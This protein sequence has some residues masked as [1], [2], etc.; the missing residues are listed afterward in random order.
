MCV[1]KEEGSCDESLTLT[2]ERGAKV[3]WTWSRPPCSLR[4]LLRVLEPKVANKAIHISPGSNVPEAPHCLQSQEG[5]AHGKGQN[6][7]AEAL[8]QL[9]YSRQSASHTLMAPNAP[10]DSSIHNDMGKSQLK[11]HFPREVFLPPNPPTPSQGKLTILYAFTKT[12]FF[13][14]EHLSQFVLRYSLVGLSD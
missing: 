6:T 14:S 5:T 2:K 8:S 9:T 3:E 4:K 7:A 11:G 1:R 12:C 10:S 13:P